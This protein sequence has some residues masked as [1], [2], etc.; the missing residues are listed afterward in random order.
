MKKHVIGGFI[1]EE[2]DDKILM[3]WEAGI[4]SQMVECEISHENMEKALRSPQDAY[5]VMVFVTTGHWPLSQEEADELWREKIRK[6]PK[7]LLIAPDF[8][9]LFNEQELNEL[10]KKANEMNMI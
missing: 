8:Q 2:T 1:I 4:N 9:K 3:K 7:Y 5:D 6:K 10:L